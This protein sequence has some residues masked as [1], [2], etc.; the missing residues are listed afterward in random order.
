MPEM[1]SAVAVGVAFIVVAVAPEVAVMMAADAVAL[2]VAWA[3]AVTVAE[4]VDAGCAMVSRLLYV[5]STSSPG[6]DEK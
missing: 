2:G 6:M 4:V 5:F 1:G 3:V